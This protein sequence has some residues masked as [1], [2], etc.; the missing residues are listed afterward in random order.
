MSTAP[1]AVNQTI[2]QGA[3][4]VGTLGA[5]GLLVDP[6]LPDGQA[7]KTCIIAMSVTCPLMDGLSA[8]QEC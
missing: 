6:G 3:N 1:V 2:V 8:E 4:P 5:A 7:A